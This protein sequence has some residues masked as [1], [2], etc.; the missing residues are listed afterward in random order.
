MPPRDC[1]DP[2][3]CSCH[4]RQILFCTLGGFT[5]LFSTSLFHRRD[6]AARGSNSM[7]CCLVH[8]YVHPP[9]NGFPQFFT[10]WQDACPSS[11]FQCSWCLSPNH[12]ARERLVKSKCW[13]CSG[14]R[15]DLQGQ[16]VLSGP[17]HGITFLQGQPR[18]RSQNP[19]SVW[20]WWDFSV[21]AG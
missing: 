18:R 20:G 8:D 12:A 6:L 21:H 13:L 19:P 11:A 3:L 5:C 7:T 9:S 16:R 14:E 1:R 2:C 4:G 10:M 15:F 17:Y